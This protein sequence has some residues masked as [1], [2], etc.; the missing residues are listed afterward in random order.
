M[1]V[2]RHQFGFLHARD[3]LFVYDC[4]GTANYLRTGSFRPLEALIANWS[5]PALIKYTMP[6]DKCFD[7][8]TLLGRERVYKAKLMPTY[9]NVTATMKMHYQLP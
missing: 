1:H 6:A 9:D 2:P 8:L 5:D 4:W 7:L 3:G